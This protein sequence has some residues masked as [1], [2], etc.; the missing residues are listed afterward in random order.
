M[1]LSD[2]LVADLLHKVSHDKYI[3]PFNLVIPQHPLITILIQN[4]DSWLD[5]LNYLRTLYQ[6]NDK[7]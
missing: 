5:I 6:T 7:R 4:S 3:C 2:L 1:V